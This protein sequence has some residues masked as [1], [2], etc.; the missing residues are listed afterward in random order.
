MGRRGAIPVAQPPLAP[1]L[2]GLVQHVAAYERLAAAP[3]P[4]ATGMPRVS[5]YLPTRSSASGSW[6]GR[7]SACWRATV[8]RSASRV[9]PM[10]ASGA[11][12][13]GDGPVLAVDGGGV[14]TDLALLDSSGAL[15]SHVRGGGSQAHYLG[16]EG[17]VEVLEGLLEAAAAARGGAARASGR[18]DRPGSAGRHRSPGGA[19]GAARRDGAA[20]VER[21]ARDRQRHRGPAARRHRPRLGGRGRVRH[22]INCLGLAPDRREARF[23]SFGPVS[24]DWGGGV[25]VGLAALAAAVR[26]ADGRGPRSAL[27]TAVP[28]HFGL[29]TRWRWRGQS[30]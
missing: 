5:R 6:R 22:G 20:S 2:L 13:G 30:I 15:L 4:P 25:D 21:T 19:L 14:K 3:R 17:C 8:S 28:A 26:A 7:C 1:E 24:G 10:T 23:L 29:T 9:G 27:E 11:P 12:S 18:I 16:V